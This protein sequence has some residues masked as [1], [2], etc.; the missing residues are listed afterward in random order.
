[1]GIAAA[2]GLQERWRLPPM[3]SLA[4]MDGLGSAL[5][6]RAEQLCRYEV[7]EEVWRASLHARRVF[8]RC[9]RFP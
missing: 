8:R 7:P 6:F 1:M 9:T 4:E 2:Q 5:L 3:K